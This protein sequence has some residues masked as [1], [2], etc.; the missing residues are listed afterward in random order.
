MDQVAHIGYSAP[1]GKKQETLTEETL[2]VHFT[3]HVE[4]IENDNPVTI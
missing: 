2:I 1:V 3:T 4:K